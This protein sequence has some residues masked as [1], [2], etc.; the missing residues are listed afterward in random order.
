MAATGKHVTFVTSSAPSSTRDAPLDGRYCLFLQKFVCKTK[1]DDGLFGPRN[2]IYWSYASANEAVPNQHTVTREY[3]SI[4]T[5]STA[6]FD[7]NI[8]FMGILNHGSW[9][10]VHIQCWEADDSKSA[11]VNKIRN[12]LAHTANNLQEGAA[13]TGQKVRLS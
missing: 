4:E 13:Q 2:E 12:A 1:Q 10:A 7:D 3:G 6:V 9:V 5:R 8:L 11:W